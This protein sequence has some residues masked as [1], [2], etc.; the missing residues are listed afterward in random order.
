MSLGAAGGVAPYRWS[1][2]GGAFPAGLALSS[3]GKTTGTP[4]S[5]ATFSFV[6]RLNDAAGGAAGVSRTI[7]VVPHLSLK[8]LCTNFCDVEQGCATV[9]GGF[10]SQSGGFGP[11]RYRIVAG[12]VPKAMG[13]NGLSLTGTFQLPAACGAN[14]GSGPIDLTVAVTDALGASGRVH[15]L[16]DVFPHIALATNKATCTQSSAG[17]S[18][19]IAYSGGTL[20]GTPTVTVGPFLGNSGNPPPPTGYTANATGGFFTFFAGGQS[21]SYT[22]TVTIVLSDQSL[23]GPGSARCSTSVT[24][25]IQL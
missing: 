8:G 1:I 20:G 4:T 9:C 13:L 23:C 25:S 22:A 5:A 17:C 18:V 7:T 3:G 6:V 12:A 14:C 19:R 11:Y 24:I 10:G 15:A 21:G 2:A 16:F